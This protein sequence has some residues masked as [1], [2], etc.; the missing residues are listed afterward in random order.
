MYPYGL[1]RA[2]FDERCRERAFDR[3]KV[4]Q[5]SRFRADKAGGLSAHKPGERHGDSQQAR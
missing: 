5:D 2:L 1:L 3:R 4:E